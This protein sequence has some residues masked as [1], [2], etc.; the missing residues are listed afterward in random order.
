MKMIILLLAL[1][2]ATDVQAQDRRLITVGAMASELVCELGHCGE[3]VAV[4]ITSVYPQ[5]LIP[6]PKVGYVSKLSAEGILSLKPTMLI[7]IDGSG[8]AQVL[9]QLGQSGVKLHKLSKELGVKAAGERILMLGK[10]LGEEEK[11]GALNKKVSSSL[12]ELYK[13]K[14]TARRA[15]KILF[16]YARGAQTLLAMGKNTTADEFIELIGGT[17]AFTVEGY[18]PVNAE[19]L[20][21]AQADIILIPDGSL[22]GLGGKEVLRGIPGIAQTPAG[23]RLAVVTVDD[24][25]LAGLGPRT[26]PA[27]KELRRKISEGMRGE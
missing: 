24:S 18:K 16:L 15:P 1:F 19:A 14:A 6:K 8:P 10:I 23:K 20:A 4:D 11:A 17:N 21:A 3:I 25:L 13:S 9:Q 27:V 5:E 7:Y 22:Q 12:A 2:F 26:A